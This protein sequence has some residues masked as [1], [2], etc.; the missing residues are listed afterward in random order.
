MSTTSLDIE[1]DTTTAAAIAAAFL[2]VSVSFYMFSGCKASGGA[3]E[4][5]MKSML[6]AVTQNGHALRHASPELKANPEVVLAAVTQNG[7]ALRHASP[8][9]KANHK[10]ALAAVKQY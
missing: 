2:A 8:E 5:A 3:S 4:S 7:H 9:L 1:G 6:A 10:V